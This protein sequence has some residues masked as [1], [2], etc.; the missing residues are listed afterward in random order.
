MGKIWID[1]SNLR[2]ARL[3]STLAGVLSE[4]NDVEVTC[5]SHA[6]T[7]KVLHSESLHYSRVDQRSP[8][9]LQHYCNRIH[10]LTR[11]VK[12]AEPDLLLTDLDP[13]AVRTAFGLGVPAWSFFQPPVSRCLLTERMSYPL[14]ERVFSSSFF[15]KRELLQAGVRPGNIEYFDGWNE[16]HLKDHPVISYG[17]QNTSQEPK[18]MVKSNGISDRWLRRFVAAVMENAPNVEISLLGRN[19]READGS[20]GINRI[21]FTPRLPPLGQSVFI[22]SGRILAESFVLGVP[23]LATEA[24]SD[25]DLE[26][27]HHHVTSLRDPR[28]IASRAID[29]LDRMR[30]DTFFERSRRVVSRLESPVKALMS[31]I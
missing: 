12:E 21:P 4:D 14:C 29:Y 1:I 23:T 17:A 7:M 16:C 3:L 2:Q 15:D 24:R 5:T 9:M 13:A 22:G 6:E 18:V 27:L 20:L 28:S 31:H 19:G 11:F 8:G 25:G 10:M 30:S 26:L